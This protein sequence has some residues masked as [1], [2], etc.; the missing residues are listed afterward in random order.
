MESHVPFLWC[1]DRSAL[2]PVALKDPDKYDLPH[3]GFF[4][5]DYITYKFGTLLEGRPGRLCSSPCCCAS[6][7][8]RHWELS[9]EPQKLQS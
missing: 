5:F 9:Q 4:T 2:Q 3:E 8:S 1:M 7:W 6:S